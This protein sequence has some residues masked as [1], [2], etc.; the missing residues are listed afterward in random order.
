MLLVA[1]L[2]IALAGFTVYR[3]HGVFGS[4]SG[5][6]TPGGGGSEIVPFNPK[7]VRLEVFGE[8]GA[9]A[10]ISYL[11]IHAR[12]RHVVDAALPWSYE[13]STTTPAVLTNISAQ[14]DGASLG[15][16]IIVDGEIKAE[17]VSDGASAYTFCLDKSG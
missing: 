5:T 17:R 16:R 12:P 10:S 8:P 1:A 13:D 2:V 9:S 15:C 7:R 6:A 4:N 14:G 11:D 3:L